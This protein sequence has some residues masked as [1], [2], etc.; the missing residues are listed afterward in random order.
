MEIQEKLRYGKLIKRYKRFLADVEFEDGQVETVHCPNSGRMTSCADPGFRVCTS[1][2][3]NPK[4]K[5]KSTFEYSHNGKSWIGVNTHR[6]NAV[7]EDG[8]LSGAIPE[9]Q[10]YDSLKREVKYGQN[11]RIDLLLEKD[12]QRCFV[13]VKNVTLQLGEGVVAFP[14]AKTERGLKHLTELCSMVEQGERAVLFFLVHRED[15]LRFVPAREIDSLY[16][17]ELERVHSLGVEVL[18]YDTKI[19][20][21]QV[22][23]RNRLPWSMS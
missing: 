11:S 21:P 18:V 5:L 20:P 10:G 4:R 14:D 19:E 8:I 13:E 22:H 6:A 9:L 2:S 15:A 16:A 12:S 1:L 3:N 23:V 7:V 17:Q